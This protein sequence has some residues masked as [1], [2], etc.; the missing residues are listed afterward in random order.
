MEENIKPLDEKA[1]E[2]LAEELKKFIGG[3]KLSEEQEKEFSNGK[4]EEDEQ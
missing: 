2:K 1:V 3:V 4:G